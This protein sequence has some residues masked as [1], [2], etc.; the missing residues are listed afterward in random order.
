MITSE[1]L[2]LRVSIPDGL[3]RPFS[4]RQDLQRRRSQVRVSIPDGLPRPFSH[5]IE[6]T[7]ANGNDIVSIPDGL[8]R[9][10]SQGLFMLDSS[11]PS[12]V[13]IP[14]G[15]PRPFSRQDQPWTQATG[16]GFQSQTGFPGHLADEI[17]EREQE[18][19]ERFNPRRASQAI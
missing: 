3:P 13:S 2:A 4:H 16:E 7:G 8:P 19:K 17:T 15:L 6:Q 11:L 5:L 12:R 10:F 9:P 1:Q 14:D 18:R